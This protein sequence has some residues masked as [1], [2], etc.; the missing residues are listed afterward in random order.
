LR[1]FFFLRGPVSNQNLG[2]SCFDLV[3]LHPT[4][5]ILGICR[6]LAFRQHPA[7]L[8]C[9]LH[10]EMIRIG[11]RNHWPQPFGYRPFL[12]SDCDQGRPGGPFARLEQ[13]SRAA[14]SGVARTVGA[15]P[16][17]RPERF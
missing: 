14:S 2:F 1:Y 17:G 10:L 6:Q 7:V 16:K 11:G 13:S 15:N 3:L 4:A 9:H 8:P 5:S 12:W